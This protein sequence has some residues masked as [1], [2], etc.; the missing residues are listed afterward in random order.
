MPVTKVVEIIDRAQTLLQDNTGTRWPRTELQKW[1][2]DAYKEII[3]A[4]PD[5]NAQSGKILLAA[6]TRQSIATTPAGALR[7]MDVV[8][9]TAAAS[10]KRAIRAIKRRILDEQMPDW[11]TQAGS[12][13][14]QHFVFDPKL[15]KEFLVYPPALTTAEVEIVYSS[16]PTPHALTDTQLSNIA[17]ADVIKL[18]DVYANAILDYVLYRGYSKDASYAGNAAR[19]SQAYSAF[20]SSLGL[21]S[22]VD[23]ATAPVAPQA[24]SD[25]A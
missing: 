21:K 23:G 4:R 14:I 16:V 5:A 25:D 24:G 18:D 2:N 3:L 17:T 7:L 9:N 13:D 8:R 1:L 22:Q 10:A 20:S 15:P 11:H 6:G 19:A 12:I